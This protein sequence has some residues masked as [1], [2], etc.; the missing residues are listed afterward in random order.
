MP[1]RDR[2]KPVAPESSRR[3]RSDHWLI[4]RLVMVPAACDVM[5]HRKPRVMKPRVRDAR[6]AA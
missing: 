2:E 6:K 3:L 5:S 4:K 1:R